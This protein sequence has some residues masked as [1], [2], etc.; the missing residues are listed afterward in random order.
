[1]TKETVKEIV[2]HNGA[3]VICKKDTA[4]SRTEFDEIKAAWEKQRDAER[5]AHWRNVKKRNIFTTLFKRKE[6]A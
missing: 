4:Y 2:A 3:I 5:Q 1:M 6:V